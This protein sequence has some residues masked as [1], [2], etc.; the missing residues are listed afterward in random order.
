[1]GGPLAALLR[2]RSALWACGE[3]AG[4]SMDIG[5]GAADGAAW[6]I[7]IFFTQIPLFYRKNHKTCILHW[8]H[9]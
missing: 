2:F 6:R 5:G 9:I 8:D 7:P 4:L 1:D 3:A